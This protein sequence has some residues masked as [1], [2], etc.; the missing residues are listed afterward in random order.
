MLDF[1]VFGFIDNAVMLAGA[2]AG[3]SV[4]KKLPKKLQTGF[5]G[6]TIGAGLGNTFSDFLGGL[7]ATNLD[8]AVGSALGCLLALFLIPCYVKL[9]KVNQ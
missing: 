6:A 7:G 8:L 9:Q 1:V 5:L 3:I 2:L 4:E